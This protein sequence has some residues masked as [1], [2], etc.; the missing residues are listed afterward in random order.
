[1]SAKTKIVELSGARYQLGKMA[2]DVGSFILMSM[3]GAGI[4]AGN[5]GGESSQT[6]PQG[7][8]AAETVSAEPRGEDMVRAVAFAAFLRGLDYEQHR[9]I[10][11][12]CLAICSRMEGEP[13]MPMPIVSGTT[14]AIPEIRDDISLVM[15]LEIEALVF[16]LSDFFD[17]GGLNTIMAGSQ[18]PA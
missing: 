5:L 7:G 12:K 10:Q 11:Q 14:W 4:K 6:P 13:E 3:I 16:N 15:K 1:M 17:A 8:R 9:F 18:V 2:P